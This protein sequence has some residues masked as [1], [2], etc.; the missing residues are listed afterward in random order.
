VAA[1]GRRPGAGS[2]SAGDRVR[3]GAGSTLGRAP[4]AGSEPQDPK[5]DASGATPGDR[6]PNRA[7][8]G[9]DGIGFLRRNRWLHERL[10]AVPEPPFADRRSGW[11]DPPGL[12]WFGT[13]AFIGSDGLPSPPGGSAWSSRT[14]LSLRWANRSRSCSDSSAAIPTST[15]H[16][17]PTRAEHDRLRGKIGR[18]A[19]SA[20]VT[21]PLPPLFS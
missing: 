10:A 11:R 9:P 2:L 14:A 13:R 5:G 20:A 16:N 3:T 12:P 18:E 8:A 1:G 15:R 4:S 6:V 17:R 21:L 19:D 7:R